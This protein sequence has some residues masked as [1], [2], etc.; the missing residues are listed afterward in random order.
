M[1]G[2]EVGQKNTLTLVRLPPATSRSLDLTFLFRMN[3]FLPRD[4]PKGFRGKSTLTIADED[5]AGLAEQI[6]TVPPTGNGC[7]RGRS[8]RGW[9]K[10]GDFF[11]IRPKY[12]F[13][14]KQLSC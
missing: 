12:P 9:G 6:H 7:G 1:E 10:K 5:A 3:N 8:L 11:L 2:F 4:A 14:V 13:F